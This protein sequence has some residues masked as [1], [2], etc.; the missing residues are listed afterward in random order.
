MGRSREEGP[1]T[2]NVYIGKE[3]GEREGKRN[4]ERERGRE[5]GKV[6]EMT[7]EWKERE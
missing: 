6:V 7:R 1:E 4:K 2:K 5:A 3:D